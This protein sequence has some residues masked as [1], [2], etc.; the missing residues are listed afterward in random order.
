MLHVQ[1]P[2][3]FK[4]DKSYRS[5]AVCSAASQSSVVQQ[6]SQTFRYI[7]CRPTG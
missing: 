4:L 2:W 1:F 7:C 6:W 3:C 5:V